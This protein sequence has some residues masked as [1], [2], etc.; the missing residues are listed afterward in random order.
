MVRAMIDA[1]NQKEKTVFF[2]D[3]RLQEVGCAV[4]TLLYTM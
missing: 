1:S 4:N 3:F 2:V